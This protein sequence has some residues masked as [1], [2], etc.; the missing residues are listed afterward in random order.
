MVILMSL[1]GPRHAARTPPLA[2]SSCAKTRGWSVALTGGLL[3]LS[4]LEPSEAELAL[5]DRQEA[6]KLTGRDLLHP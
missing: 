1:S 4:A 5:P 3:P 2:S 6:L